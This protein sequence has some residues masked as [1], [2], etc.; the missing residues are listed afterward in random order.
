MEEMKSYLGT[1]LSQ[2]VNKIHWI[3]YDTNKFLRNKR[4]SYAIR[5]K[6]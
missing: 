4:H 5:I 3:I 6:Y 1:R 2:N